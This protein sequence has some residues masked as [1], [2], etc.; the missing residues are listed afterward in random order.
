MFWRNQRATLIHTVD[1]KS[2]LNG[3]I[4]FALQKTGNFILHTY[5]RPGILDSISSSSANYLNLQVELFLTLHHI[6]S[7]LILLCPLAP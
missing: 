1:P 2:S 7:N 6:V 4:R 3:F 5:I